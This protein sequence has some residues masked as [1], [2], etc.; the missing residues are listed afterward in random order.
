M[1]KIVINLNPQKENA[2]SEVMRNIVGYTPLVVLGAG[3]IF[4]VI[5]LLQLIAFSKT[6]TYNVYKAKWAQWEDKDRLLKEIKTDI[7]RLEAEKAAIGQVAT[8]RYE[9]AKIFADI[10][11]ALPKNIW[12]S[13][14]SFQ[15]DF[16]SLQ[17]NVVR[18][19]EDYLASLDKFI[20]KLRRSQYF[21]TRFQKINIKQS[22]KT[23]F[24]G[25]EVLQFSL[26]CLK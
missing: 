16:L 20:D 14:I 18:W 1:N 11:S 7:E 25:V 13:N 19:N 22:Q 5:V 24:N 15:K 4:V 10:F 26:E 3:F 8:A 6:H 2:P 9:M 23:N 17:G 21:S 12:F